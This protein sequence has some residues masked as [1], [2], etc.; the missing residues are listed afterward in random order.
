M[1]YVCPQTCPKQL[2]NGPCGGTLGGQCEVVPENPCIWVAVYQ[3][4]KDAGEVE[5]LKVYLPPPNRDLQGTS[6]YINYFLA[7]DSRPDARSSA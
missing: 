5:S 6:S 2:R 7:R 3:R 4:A 1:E